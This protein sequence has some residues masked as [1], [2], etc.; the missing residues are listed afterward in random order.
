M[1]KSVLLIGLGRFGYHMA[2]RMQ[3]LKDEVLGVDIDE[4]KVEQ[5]LS[6]DQRPDCRRHRRELYPHPGG[7]QL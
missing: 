7:T 4:D 1:A 3:E 6:C 2:E 5:C